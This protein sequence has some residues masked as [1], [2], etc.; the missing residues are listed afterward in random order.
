VP[1]DIWDVYANAAIHEVWQWWDTHSYYRLGLTEEDATANQ[2]SYM[3]SI[4]TS[5]IFTPCDGLLV[6][7]VLMSAQA[8][9]WLPETLGK[10]AYFVG[11]VGALASLG[12]D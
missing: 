9:P 5:N 10:T 2:L 11:N 1:G 6:G 8:T 3:I 4:D 12:C 7:S